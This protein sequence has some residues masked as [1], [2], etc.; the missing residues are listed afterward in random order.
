MEGIIQKYINK[1]LEQSESWEENVCRIVINRS[2]IYKSTIRSINRKKFSFFK[3][4]SVTFS[5]EEA[6]DTGGPKREYLRLLMQEVATLKIFQN[7]WFKH[8]LIALNQNVYA[9]VGQ[10]IAWSILQG[11]SGPKCLSMSIYNFISGKTV[12]DNLHQHIIDEDLKEILA[13]L[14]RTSN[15]ESFNEFLDKYS[16]RICD[17]GYVN[18][19]ITKYGDKLD[20]CNALLKHQFKFSVLAEIQQF[21]DGMNV[22][23]NFGE[24]IWNNNNVFESILSDKQE[25]LTWQKFKE[26][27]SNDYSE[28]GSNKR[29]VENET[30]YSWEMFLQDV[31]EKEVDV[32]FGDLLIFITGTNSIPPLGF[33]NKPCIGFYD[34]EI[35][36]R[37]LPWSSTCSNTL[38]LPRNVDPAML[39]SMIIQSLLEGHGFGKV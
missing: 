29:I 23:G 11:C 35:K 27:F 2:D 13:V 14:N 3:P 20:I 39:K 30:I 21:K 36:E 25:D 5:G 6:V 19:Y 8:D 26:L 28:V 1:N 31:N 37:R 10:L 12:D 4:L 16:D 18:I 22:I 17:Y 34:L 9:L 24:C 32:K 15:D 7:D 33:T 38:Y